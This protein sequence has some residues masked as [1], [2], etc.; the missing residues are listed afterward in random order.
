MENLYGLGDWSNGVLNMAL[1]AIAF[2]A[3]AIVIS[4]FKLIK[5]KKKFLDQPLDQRLMACL[6]VHTK[7]SKMALKK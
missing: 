4:T 3:I 5:P 6:L 7:G 2:T 1:V